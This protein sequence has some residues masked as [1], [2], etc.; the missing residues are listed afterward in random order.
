M[1]VKKY[2]WAS[3]RLEKTLPLQH[4]KVCIKEAYD[5]EAYTAPAS[6]TNTKT[7]YSILSKYIILLAKYFY[8]FLQPGVDTKYIIYLSFRDWL[9]NNLTSFFCTH[10]VPMNHAPFRDVD[11]W[12]SRRITGRTQRKACNWLEGV[13]RRWLDEVL[14]GAVVGDGGFPL[15]TVRCRAANWRR[16]NGKLVILS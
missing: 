12:E 1:D 14:L 8:T 9:F 4:S 15:S 16:E 5:R 11:Q 13:G 7:L 3:G 6:T 2:E 10:V